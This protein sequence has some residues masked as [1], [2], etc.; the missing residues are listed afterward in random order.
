MTTAIVGPEAGAGLYHASFGVRT[1]ARYFV[2][3]AAVAV[4]A[5]PNSAA[6]SGSRA[7]GL[8]FT[9]IA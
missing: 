4:G 3:G 8:R 2:A 6:T 1:G 5:G 9:R 7:T